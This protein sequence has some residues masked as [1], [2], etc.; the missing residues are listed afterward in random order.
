MTEL[1]E[2]MMYLILKNEG[3]R[4]W[5]DGSVKGPDCSSRGPE[6][7]SQQPHGGSQPSLMGSDALSLCD[8]RQLQCIHVNKINKSLKI[9]EQS[10]YIS[11]TM[12]DALSYFISLL[13]W[14][15]KKSIHELAGYYV[16]FISSQEYLTPQKC[17]ISLW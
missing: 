7:N 1:P 5:R 15:I 8:W 14:F 4:G 6:F 12:L 10:L 16:M 9:R 17:I 2:L 11:Q 13:K 3:N